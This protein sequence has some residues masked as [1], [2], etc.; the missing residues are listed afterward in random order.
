MSSVYLLASDR[1]RSVVNDATGALRTYTPYGLVEIQ[2]G[3]MS[4]FCGERRDPLSGCYHLGSGYRQFNP[5]IMRFNSPDALSPFGKGGINAYV[6]CQ[7]DPLNRHDPTGAIPLDLSPGLAVT[8]HGGSLA[9]QSAGPK[10]TG[11]FAKAAA[12][13]GALGSATTVVGN[14]LELTG[15]QKAPVVKAVGNALVIGGLIGRVLKY[16]M[17]DPKTALPRMWG[18]IK[19]NV[20]VM[21]GLE[22]QKKT[23]PN[24][25]SIEPS[26]ATNPN[27]AVNIDDISSMESNEVTTSS[28]A[29][30]AIS[31]DRIRTS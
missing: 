7:S 3:P 20:P 24:R 14:V 8:L 25:S 19:V 17:D 4:A 15:H 21:L 6:Y 11:F 2:G 16:V 5:A 18:N 1:Q 12:R 10:I 13:T 31:A 29:E 28:S 30:I 9:F 23:V 26:G 27:V 22:G